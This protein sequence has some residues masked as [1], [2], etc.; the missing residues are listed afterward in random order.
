[1]TVASFKLFSLAVVAAVS[2]SKFSEQGRRNDAG[3]HIM[4]AVTEGLGKDV[5]SGKRSIVTI[6]DSWPNATTDDSPSTRLQTEPEFSLRMPAARA[7]C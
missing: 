3:D 6:L 5:P 1:V 7:L 4:L 2:T